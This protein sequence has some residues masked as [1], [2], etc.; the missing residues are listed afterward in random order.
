MQNSR[1]DTVDISFSSASS[2]EHQTSSHLTVD[3]PFAIFQC[4]SKTQRISDT[5]KGLTTGH[6]TIYEVTHFLPP[7][8]VEKYTSCVARMSTLT[9]LH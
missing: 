6:I 2:A 8:F 3:T 5:H 9:I 7:N 1:I 4:P